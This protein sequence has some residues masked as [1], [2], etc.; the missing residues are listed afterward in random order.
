MI[1]RTECSAGMEFS[2]PRPVTFG[3]QDARQMFSVWHSAVDVAE[4]RYVILGTGYSHPSPV[5]LV[6]SCIM[7]DGFHVFHLC[8]I[9]P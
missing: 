3:W 5:E 6:A 4:C 9:M 8:R 7:P 1:H 2:A